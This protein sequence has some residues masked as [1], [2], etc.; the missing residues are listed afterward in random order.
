M[1]KEM[2]V[3]T[4]SA[5]NLALSVKK[6]EV[7]ID[8]VIGKPSFVLIGLANRAVE[9]SKERISA[10]LLHCGVRIKPLRTVVNLAPAELKKTSSALELAIAVALLIQYGEVKND[11]Q[12]ALF[13]GELSLTGQL[14]AVKGILGV[15]LQAKSMGFSQL[16]FP[17]ANLAELILIKDLELFPLASLSEFISLSKTRSLDKLKTKVI[18]FQSKPV[19][20]KTLQIPDLAEFQ[21]QNQAKR[22]LSICA[23][24]GHHL[25]LFGEPGAGKTYLAKSIL[26]IV[27]ELTDKEIL[28]INQIYS[29]LSPLKDG[30]LVQRPFRQPH[31]SI[32]KAA[33]LGGLDFPGE[34]SLA[35][36]GILFLDEFTELR[37]D[38]IE[39]LRQPL[40]NHFFKIN[41]ARQELIYPANFT[42]IAAANP[43]PCGFYASEKACRCSTYDLLRYQKKLSGPI[44]DR[45]DLSIR[46]KANC[47][48]E[49]F[50]DSASAQTS[51][52]IRR[53]VKLAKERQNRRFK[54]SPFSSNANLSSEGVKRFCK[55]SK[56][57]KK[58]LDLARTQLKLSIRAY[59]KTIKVAQTISD[60]QQEEMILPQAIAE[61]LS[62]L[63]TP[64]NEIN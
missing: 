3:K 38:L 8:T 27:P 43:C 13:L 12:K 61:A 48:R 59:F 44:L 28:E 26:S 55:L 20:N 49:L 7:E 10:A 1:I 15:A 54:D 14:K 29:L 36:L 34:L 40:E 46:I 47:Q 56:E 30:L 63:Q 5:I 18:N 53:R 22:A 19:E 9:E 17:E 51:R 39:A 16:F 35:H 23:A 24:G 45:I 25:L 52:I 33:F 41:R 60:F 37:R 64:I 31:H 50:Y 57:A 4:Y 62:F 58:I 2:F 11:C 32:S 42:L 6:I 21:G